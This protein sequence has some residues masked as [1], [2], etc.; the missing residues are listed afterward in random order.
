VSVSTSIMR[1][2]LDR[3]WVRVVGHRDVPGRPAM[4]ATTREFL[5]YFG[6]KSLDQL[7]TLAEIR[8]LDSVNVELEFGPL[9][10]T[11]AAPLVEDSGA[12]ETEQLARPFLAAYPGLSG[13]EQS[14]PDPGPDDEEAIDAAENPGPTGE[15]HSRG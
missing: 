6:L 5:D 1:T 11:E 13:V 12:E 8:D 15:S 14:D 3:G 9:E 4:Y 10:E 2:M 7:P